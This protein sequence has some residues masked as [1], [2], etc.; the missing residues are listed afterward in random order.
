MPRLDLA[1]SFDRAGEVHAGLA[2]GQHRRARRAGAELD[3][4]ARRRPAAL[5]RRARLAPAAAPHSLGLS[6]SGLQ[7]AEMTARCYAIAL[8]VGLTAASRF[9]ISAA[10]CGGLNR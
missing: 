7:A 3:A 1:S 4:A 5:Y 8:S 9:L 2:D 10:G 6:V